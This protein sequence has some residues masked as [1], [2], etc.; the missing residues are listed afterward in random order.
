MHKLYIGLKMGQAQD[1]IKT[2]A[3]ELAEKFSLP[4]EVVTGLEIQERDPV[5]KQIR[6]A[7]AVAALLESILVVAE[8]A[9]PETLES[10]AKKTKAT[11]Q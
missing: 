8:V 4:A 10:P 3:Q 11:K 2:A 6:I 1:R 7:E 9:V 5:V